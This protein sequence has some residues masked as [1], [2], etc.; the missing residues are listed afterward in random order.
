MKKIKKYLILGLL[1]IQMFGSIPAVFAVVNNDGPQAPAQ[2]DV[3]PTPT[4]TP[5]TPATPAAPNSLIQQ[6][7]SKE[8][9]QFKVTDYLKAKD[10]GS[11]YLGSKAP[12]ASFIIQIINF[13]VLTIGSLSFLVILIGGFMYLV[14]HGNETL[15]NKAKE[16]ITYAIMGLV[17]SLSAYFIVAFVQ[18]IFYGL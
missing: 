9:Q 17:I 8:N 6:G 2:G 1:L 4:P 13:L 15:I 5:A 10:Q 12:I 16:A 3:T 18:S 7:T 11:A 14:S